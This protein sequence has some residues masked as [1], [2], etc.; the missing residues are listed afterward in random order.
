MTLDDQAQSIISHYLLE[1]ALGAGGMGTVY[2]GVDQ[3]DGSPVAVKI[4]HPHL[5]RDRGFRSRFEREAHL[6]ALL[7]SPYT[8]H[9]MDYGVI[10]ER[11]FL[12]MEYIDGQT[13]G[14]LLADGPL[15]PAR[16]LLIAAQVA[17]ALEEAHARGVVHRDIKPENILLRGNDSVKV[18]D[19]GISCRSGAATLSGT[20]SFYGTPAYAA[21]EQLDGT[22]DVRSDIYALGATLFHMVA[23]RAPF[24][25][26]LDELPRQIR[27]QPVALDSLPVAIAPIVSRC[28]EKSPEARYQSASEVAADLER[29]AKAIADVQPLGTHED[30]ATRVLSS[31]GDAPAVSLRLTALAR[32]SRI[33]ARLRPSVYQLAVVNAG[34]EPVEIALRAEDRGGRCRFTLPGRV[35][36]PGGSEGT[37]VI[38]VRPATRRWRGRLVTRIFTVYGESGGGGPP[39][40]ASARFEDLPF[41]WLPYGAVAGI[42]AVAALIAGVAMAAGVGEPEPGPEPLKIGVLL[43]LS[44]GTLQPGTSDSDYMLNAARIAVSEIN[45]DGGVLGQPVVLVTGDSAGDADVAAQ[46]ARRLVDDGVHAIIG[47]GGYNTLVVANQ[48]SQPSGIVQIAPGLGWSDADTEGFV[49]SAGAPIRN[50]LPFLFKTGTPVDVE[51]SALASRITEGGYESACVISLFSEGMAQPLA[52]YI[53]DVRVIDVDHDES[54]ISGE[55]EPSTQLQI[56]AAASKAASDSL[57]QCDGAEALVLD[58]QTPSEIA[59]V[60]DAEAAGGTA[61]LLDEALNKGFTKILMTAAARCGCSPFDVSTPWSGLRQAIDAVGWERMSSVEGIRTAR[62]QSDYDAFFI[63]YGERFGEPPPPEA[64]NS[65]AYWRGAYDAVYLIALAAAQAGS[66]DPD[67]IRANLTEIANAPGVRVEPGGGARLQ[68]RPFMKALELIASGQ[69]VDY[70]GE[71]GP[72][73]FDAERN[74][75]RALVEAWHLDPATREAVAERPFLID[76]G[77]GEFGAAL[78]NLASVRIS[79]TRFTVPVSVTSR[80]ASAVITDDERWFDVSG[81][82]LQDDSAPLIY[83]L[84]PLDVVESGS[85]EN[86]QSLPDDLPSWIAQDPR[87][88]VVRTSEMTIGGLPALQMDL[89]GGAGDTS[90]FGFLDMGLSSIGGPLNFGLSAD[91]PARLFVLQVDGHTIVIAAVMPFAADEPITGDIRR[92][93]TTLDDVLPDI[94]AMLATVE[95]K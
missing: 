13:L 55:I 34:A 64:F 51:A 44:G 54:F 32:G 25:G 37:A 22:A 91:Q 87:L 49:D 66:T 7:R 58:I 36:V 3:R 52:K 8:V 17:R 73:Q 15:G 72:I 95:F 24:A 78:E 62:F 39:A 56:S 79:S 63:Q 1:G 27:E 2:A 83:F 69:D 19:F 46:E 84:A 82:S 68:S 60:S 35:T 16:A 26:Q 11:C 57:E 41:G 5:A 50:D 74:N 33:A 10:D 14:Q 71:A 42:A 94:E 53:S 43:P 93:S 18:S 67:A 85:Q 86:R 21:P 28:L 12:V 48:V 88:E 23:G 40:G 45:A 61:A 76:T 81:G 20:G 29:A 9:L 31:R 38:K 77:T 30:L 92:P 90:A 47:E 65:R 75:T 70:E 4:L 89:R 6:A 59:T 80:Y